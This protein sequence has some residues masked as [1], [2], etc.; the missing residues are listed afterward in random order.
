[1]NNETIHRF[2]RTNEVVCFE[3]AI[4]TGAS[5]SEKDKFGTTALPYS[6]SESNHDITRCLLE[7][8][9]DMMT[10]MKM[11]RQV[12]DSLGRH[13]R[14]RLHDSGLRGLLPALGRDYP[15]G[16]KL[17]GGSCIVLGLHH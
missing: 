5:I 9:A 17:D 6:I 15:S 10:R 2:A 12:D 7:H 14:S 8:G 4:E 11:V 13:R 3:E 16:A 1:V